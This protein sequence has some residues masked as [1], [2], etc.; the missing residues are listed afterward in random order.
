MKV[1]QMKNQEK[2]LLRDKIIYRTRPRCNTDK[3]TNRKHD[4]EGLICR[5]ATVTGQNQ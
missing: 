5:L 3:E 1:R 4:L 2:R